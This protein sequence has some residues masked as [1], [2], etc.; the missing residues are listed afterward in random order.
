MKR[1][2]FLFLADLQVCLIYQKIIVFTEITNTVGQMEIQIWTQE[3]G[4][5]MNF[6]KK[7][8]KNSYS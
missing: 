4:K 3:K 1:I 2:K 5:Q 6:P 8:L 7:T